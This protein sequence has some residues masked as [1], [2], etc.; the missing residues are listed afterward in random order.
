MQTRSKKKINFLL[1][2]FILFTCVI[3]S[4]IFITYRHMLSK[5]DNLIQDASYNASITINNIHHTATKEGV[6]EWSLDAKRGYFVSDKNQAVL[7]EVSITFFSKDGKNVYLNAMNGILSTDSN[8]MEL[9]GNIIVKNEGYQ[10]KTESLYYTHKKK[11]IF[12]KLPVEILGD[13]FKISAS[14]MLYDLNTKKTLLDGHV[15]GHFSEKIS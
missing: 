4:L 9:K 3:I 12:S 7:E 6:K 1:K 13:S 10:L 5:V 14:S 8:N 2:V 15:E 11:I